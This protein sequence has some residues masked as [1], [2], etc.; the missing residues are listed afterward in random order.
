MSRRAL[1]RSPASPR[2]YEEAA[3]TP[4]RPTRGFSLLCCAAILLCAALKVPGL[5]YAA[6]EPDE[7]IYWQLAENLARTGTYSLQGSELLKELSP[8]I[9]DR[10]LFH[11]PPLFAAALTPFVAAGAKPFAVLV[12]WLGH[13]L[14]VLAVALV[15]RHAIRRQWT[16]ATVTSPSFWLPVFGV[17]ADPLLL[18]VSKR[19]WIDSLLAGLVALSTATLIMA[20]GSRRRLLLGL[21]GLLLGLAALAK[22][23][24]LILLPVFL[25]V[26][27]RGDGNWKDR[28]ASGLAIVLPIAVLVGPW[29]AT[30]YAQ[31]GVFVPGWVRPDAKLLEI[32]PFLQVAV[33]RPWYYYAVTLTFVLP[34]V[35]APIWPLIREP[36]IRQEFHIRAA[37]AWFV[38]FVVAQ[39]LLGASGYGFQMRHIAP[40][41]AAVYVVVLLIL[42]QRDRP[43]LL[44]ACGCSIIFSVATG[45]MHL[46]APQFDEMLSLPGLAGLLLS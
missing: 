45:A 16:A 22:L 5:I 28:A 37:V 24:A 27:L 41:V 20:G 38:V 26:G 11:H 2:S 44:M 39:T 4:L 7:R 46:L 42:L 1:K 34:L 19:V 32:Y 35:L 25:V 33:A 21:A 10:S 43:V 31:F 14:A 29:L 18:F 6:Q 36:D 17:A 15:G 3:E 12:S 40:A 23:S 9:Y 8:E 30:F 13:F